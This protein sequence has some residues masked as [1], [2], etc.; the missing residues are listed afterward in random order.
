MARPYW[1]Q[2]NLWYVSCRFFNPALSHQTYG[3]PGDLIFFHGFGNNIL[4]LNS[5]K[6][7][8]DLLDKRGE[9]YSD[10]PVF[11]VVGELMGLGQV[12]LRLNRNLW[13]DSCCAQSLPLLPYGKEW[14]ECRKLA[15]VALSATAIKKYH[16]TQEDMA[17]LLNKALLQDPTNFFSHVRT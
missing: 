8:N 2:K 5:M 9:I 17:A 10:R 16:R 13:R 1:I 6:T 12:K 7:I 4:V 15:H 11:T 14:R 3:R